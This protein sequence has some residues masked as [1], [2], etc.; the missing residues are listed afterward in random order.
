MAHII[1]PIFGTI[2]LV[3]AAIFTFLLL[4]STNA[5]TASPPRGADAMGLAIVFFAMGGRWLLMLI[6]VLICL[7]RGSFDWISP[8]PGMPTLIALGAILGLGVFF[9]LSW[10]QWTYPARWYTPL[11][12][13]VGA[14]LLPLIVQAY[15]ITILWIPASRPVPQLVQV[16]SA[17]LL[18]PAVL[19]LSAGGYMLWRASSE[20]SARVQQQI[21]ESQTKHAEH[22]RRSSL[23]HTERLREDLNAMPPGSQFWQIAGYFDDCETDE[24]RRMVAALIDRLMKDDEQ[25]QSNLVCQYPSFRHRAAVYLLTVDQP[26]ERLG[27]SLVKAIEL[28][29]DTIAEKKSLLGAD[30]EDYAQYAQT[31]VAAAHRFPNTSFEE[32]DA[33]LRIV[34][35]ALP[36]SDQRTL[37]LAAFIRVGDAAVT[38]PDSGDARP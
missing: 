16:S 30:G 23:S 31:L 11:L 17:A 5:F 29:T 14:G 21:A 12:G 34:I 8:R 38:R 33:K 7:Y 9:A 4:L 1:L 19:G 18:V 15:L 26:S 22:T 6:P 37:A 32:A 2:C 3:I 35:E 27:P 13:N 10:I 25:L 28:L 20:R 24:Q 36:P